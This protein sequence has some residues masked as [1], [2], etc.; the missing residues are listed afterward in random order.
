MD[1]ENV[2]QIG[3]REFRHRLSEVVNGNRQ[4]VVTNNGKDVGEFTPATI[5]APNAEPSRWL[6]ERQAFRRRWQAETPDWLDRLTDAGMDEEGE[7]FDQPTF[8]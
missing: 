8:R 6:E 7:P 1:T 3:V 2:V 5:K 4:V